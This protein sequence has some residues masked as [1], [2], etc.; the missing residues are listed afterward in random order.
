M[1]LLP[2]SRASLVSL[3]AAFLGSL[4]TA[5]ARADAPSANKVLAET[6]FRD[7]KALLGQGKVHEACVRFA[8]SQSYDPQLGTLLNLAL[9]HEQEGRTAT[10]WVELGEVVILA[11]R[12]GQED[13]ATFAGEHARA[14]E[15]NLS[16]L[17]VRVAE[18]ADGLV[19][20]LVDGLTL[21]PSAWGEALPVDPGKHTVEASAPGKQ[22]MVASALVAVGFAT[23]EVT[24]GPLV[25]AGAP[26]TSSSARDAE[27]PASRD[28][29]RTLGWVALGTGV[30]GLAVGG[31]FGIETF[32]KKGDEG[33]Y[34][35]KFCSQPGLDDQSASRT[36]ATISTVAFGVG[37]AASAVGAYLVLKPSHP[38]I[39]TSEGFDRSVRLHVSPLGGA[40]AGGLRVGGA[41]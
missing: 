29:A 13:R 39:S 16:R 12:E 17:R 4:S 37:I 8:D 9:C 23:V 40:R 33:S 1:R 19:T 5:S 2:G 35:T 41:W 36:D 11:R 6:L 28:L 38:K 32:V 22:R 31:I 20:V 7:A 25:N 18:P 27:T 34:C 26:A 10:A 14:L 21:A 15:A 3:A 30:A 24:L